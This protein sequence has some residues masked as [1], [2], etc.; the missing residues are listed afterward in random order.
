M[1]SALIGSDRVKIEQSSFSCNSFA[2]RSRYSSV[3]KWTANKKISVRDKYAV[4]R[5]E[6]GW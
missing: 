4:R 2:G 1:K 5:D 3:L 6:I